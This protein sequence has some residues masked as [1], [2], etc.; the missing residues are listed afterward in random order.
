MNIVII[1]TSNSVMKNS[2]VKS[3]S[4][5]NIVTNLSTGRVPVFYHI[6]TILLN[7]DKL[8]EADVIIIDHYINDI[9]FYYEK[10]DDYTFHTENLYKIL[11]SLNKPVLNLLFPCKKIKEKNTIDY[12]CYIKKLTK[13]YGLWLLDLNEYGFEETHFTDVLHLKRN[14]SYIIGNM[15]SYTL[16]NHV[17]LNEK[18][19]VSFFNNPYYIVTADNIKDSNQHY[20]FENFKNSLLSV[21]FITAKEGGTLV[22]KNPTD[23]ELQLLSL[24][25][26]NKTDDLHIGIIHSQDTIIPFS[27]GGRLYLHEYFDSRI[28]VKDKF[29]FSINFDRDTYPSLMNRDGIVR[30]KDI[31]CGVNICE[32]LLY[33][34]EEIQ[35]TVFPQN[36]QELSIS[37]LMEVISCS[38]MEQESYK[39]PPKFVDTLRDAA[40]EFEQH[41]IKTSYALMLIARSLRPSGS[42]IRKKINEYEAELN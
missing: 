7:M 30:G 25:Y 21:N 5:H 34:G 6:R 9:N 15:L 28:W 19:E 8:Y 2:Y 38:T 18:R 29:Q 1:G 37:N 42:L 40:I 3:L 10:I 41:N 27:V 14:V 20:I 35:T 31:K 24:G 23:K 22:I 13:N 36:Y 4:L 32:F 16:H 17:N 33:S 26:F 11:G 39:I 12:Y